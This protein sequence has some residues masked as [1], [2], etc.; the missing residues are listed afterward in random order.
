VWQARG[1][2]VEQ[3][4]TNTPRRI[5]RRQRDQGHRKGREGPFLTLANDE[6]IAAALSLEDRFRRSLDG[7]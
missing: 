3:N 4:E 6:Q 5:L 7:V 1:R 2:T